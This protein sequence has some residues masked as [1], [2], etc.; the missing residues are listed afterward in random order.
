MSDK[1]AHFS[2]TVHSLAGTPP[3][4]ISLAFRRLT[5]TDS[6]RPGLAN[7]R[8]L[9]L[10]AV[11]GVVVRLLAVPFSMVNDGDA[12]ARTWIAWRWLDR[13]EFI[14]SGE[15]G[16]LHTYL[17]AFALAVW[18]DPV[19]APIFLN[20]ALSVMTAIPL[21]YFT[22]NEFRNDRAALLV[23]GAWVL[24]P[25]AVRNSLMPLADT[26]FT[27]FMAMCL[28]FLSLARQP[29]GHWWHALAA[30]LS[31]TA[32]GMLRFEGWLLIPLLAIALLR[33]PTL[34][35]PF[36]AASLVFPMFWVIGNRIQ[37]G[38]FLYSFH[39]AENW[40]AVMDVRA[41]DIAEPLKQLAYYPLL[42]LFGTT[43]LLAVLCIAGVGRSWLKL[44]GYAVWSIPVI[45]LLALYIIQ[46]TRSTLVLKG[47]YTIPL[48]FLL[49]PF[50]A[51]IY[52]AI[53]RRLGN[54]RRRRFVLLV[55]GTIIPLSYIGNLVPSERSREFFRS[56]VNA[57]PRLQD[58]DQY[59]QFSGRVNSTLGVD[60]NAGF[61]TDFY[62][63]EPT[64]YVAFMT[65]LEPDRIYLVPGAVGEQLD[66]PLL[67][68]FVEKH[69]TGTM[70]LRRGSRF[71]KAIHFGKDRAVLNNEVLELEP[72]A[73][74]ALQ[75]SDLTIYHYRL[76]HMF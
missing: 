30:G 22:R 37:N 50:V 75:Q 2:R 66:L 76:S 58:G 39:W 26:P 5:A 60:S 34:L 33:R 70:I 24:Y 32:A 1:I 48:T 6:I 7:W 67:V 61:I 52:D 3:R 68:N 49:L 64:T 8:W 53:C 54:E 41:E 44:R 74:S 12:V 51:A 20:S 9:L 17:I 46:A 45:F 11:I 47:R 57:V 43:P 29:S 63:W 62:G 18:R 35:V 65:R 73:P 19:G 38:D 69:Q 13:P 59:A 42:I 4:T 40:N 31:L 28:F 23:A 27:F 71:C 55:L 25:L 16:P 36:V 15:W 21:Y 72:L 14:T 10:I 56:S